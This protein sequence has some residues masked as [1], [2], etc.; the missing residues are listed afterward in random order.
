MTSR[1]FITSDSSLY[2]HCQCHSAPVMP[3]RK[4][5]KAARQR[6]KGLDTSSTQPQTPPESTSLSSQAAGSDAPALEFPSSPTP[7]EPPSDDEFPAAVLLRTTRSTK[8]KSEVTSDTSDVD[9]AA[10][11][12][13]KP[14]P[15]PKVQ[16]VKPSSENDSSDLR[17][18]PKPA[19]KKPGPKQ[20][21]KAKAV[22]KSRKLKKIVFM[23]PEAAT[24]GN[25][26]V[27]VKS[28]TFFDDVV[29][30]MHETIGCVGVERK[31][32]LAYKFSTAIK[33]A[34]TINLRT[35][36]D[37]E[38]LVADVLAKMKTKKD[39]SI[40]ISVLPENYMLSLRAKNKKKTVTTTGKRKGEDDDDEDV[41]AGEKKVLSELEA[42]YRKCVRCGPSVMC[43]I[44]RGGNH[45]SLSFPQRRAWAV[46]LACGTKGVT[47]TTPPVAG[48]LFSMFHGTP[49]ALTPPP[50]PVQSHPQYP[51]FPPMPPVGY[52]MPGFQ[53]PGYMP[54]GPPAPAHHAVMSSDPPDDAAAYPSIVDFIETLIAKVPQ[55]QS[56]REAGQNLDAL[57]YYNIDELTTL[58]V[59]EFGTDKFGN[60]L[61]GNAEYLLGQVKKEVKRLDKLARRARL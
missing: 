18:E 23:I 6:K 46:S 19:R 3:S 21:P 59:D 53:I 1:D 34:S 29:E 27:S 13:K 55:R 20:Q 60:I 61:R 31:P 11:A 37:W 15:K 26:R 36:N 8:R 25:Q 32:T 24:E 10:P 39:I 2:A 9:L 38:G 4:S 33:S 16:P 49:K 7:I 51:Y 43:K 58:T 44:D 28:S 42:E 14:G 47:K 22:P 12:K 56:L 30:L 40:N 57:A 52:G 48:A 5:L 45:V 41:E 17:I 35:N 50:L 54:A